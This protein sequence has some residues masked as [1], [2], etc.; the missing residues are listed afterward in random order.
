[1][2]KNHECYLGH[3]DFPTQG[4]LPNFQVA[5]AAFV[6]ASFVVVDTAVVVVAAVVEGGIAVAV[7]VEHYLVA[8]EMDHL[9]FLLSFGFLMKEN[10]YV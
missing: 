1:M 4:L 6:A 2:F 3:F 8:M 5:A 10:V 7:V 9:D